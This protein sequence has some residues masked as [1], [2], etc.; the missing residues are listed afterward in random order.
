MPDSPTSKPARVLLAVFSGVAGAALVAVAFKVDSL[1]WMVD[2]PGW[3]VNRFVS[4]DFHEGEGA[5][6]FFFAI[7]LSWACWSVAVWLLLGIRR[8]L[9]RAF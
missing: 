2:G 7:F 6:G 8:L 1:N 5:F 3:L 4:I 9:R